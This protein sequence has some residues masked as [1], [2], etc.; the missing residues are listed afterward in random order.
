LV[1]L[2]TRFFL[3][4][5]WLLRLTLLQVLSGKASYYQIRHE[6]KVGRAIGAGKKPLRPSRGEN[7]VEE[8]S[9]IVWHPVSTCWEFEAKDRPG[10]LQIQKVFSSMV[11]HDDRPVPKPTVPPGAF[12]H[13]KCSAHL[14]LTRSIL[15]RLIGFDQSLPPP[16]KIPEHLQKL[17]S[18]LTDNNAKAETVAVAAGQLGSDDTQ[19]LVDVLDLV[20]RSYLPDHQIRLTHDFP[21][22]LKSIHPSSSMANLL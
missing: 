19:I 20:S 1:V 17:L 21:R 14:N 4:L 13:E 10:C 12:E 8:I 5:P 18:G 15:T 11:V 16:S 2:F 3:S 7:G 6:A 9:D 22:L